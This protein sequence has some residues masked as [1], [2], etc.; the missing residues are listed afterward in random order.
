MKKYETSNIRLKLSVKK[1]ETSFFVKTYKYVSAR[2]FKNNFPN[3]KEYTNLFRG[4]TQCF[5]RHNIAKHCKYLL[6][7]SSTEYCQLE[8]SR[9][10]NQ[11]GY[12]HMRRACSLCLLV[13]RNEVWYISSMETSHSASQETSQQTY[14]FLVEEKNNCWNRMLVPH[15]FLKLQWNSLGRVYIVVHESQRDACLGKLVF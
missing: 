14:N 8:R 2:C 5:G 9:S 7:Y 1:K 10:W 4:Y 3:L 13:R 12:F 11:D 6:V 15:V